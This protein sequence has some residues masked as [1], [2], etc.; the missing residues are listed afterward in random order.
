[1]GNK[2]WKWKGVDNMNRKILLITVITLLLF[3]CKTVD[4]QSGG[5]INLA[6]QYSNVEVKQPENA[7]DPAKLDFSED[8]AIIRYDR[9][10]VLT[11]NIETRPDGSIHKKVDFQPQNPNKLEITNTTAKVDTGS[12]YE[13][14]VGQLNVFLEN[15]KFIMWAGVG[16]LAAGGLFAG[17]LRDI[18]SGL[19]L[20][21]IGIAMLGGYALLPQIYSNWLLVLGVG[22]V[23]IPVYWFLSFKQR[24][25]IS[26]AS[27]IA[28]EK[29]KAKYPD[30]AKEMSAEFKAILY[31]EDI[32]L[33]RKIKN[34]TV[35]TI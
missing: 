8:G 24:N 18:R 34:P 13:D 9:G 3:G 16:F 2:T 25:R 23:A 10:D 26:H 28:Y 27:V 33:A 29:I 31:P 14:M 6:T 32:E 7:E 20:S 19:I 30:V 1:M 5:Q 12:S 35:R 17:F 21:G 4:R 11:L 15:S 22:A